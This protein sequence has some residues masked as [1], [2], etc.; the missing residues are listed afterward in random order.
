MKISQQGYLQQRKRLNP[1]IF[2]TSNDEYLIDFYESSEAGLCSKFR[3]ASND[4]RTERNKLRSSW[5]D[6]DTN[7]YRSASKENTP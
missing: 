2:S 4:Y 7:S 6:R 1:D 3:L 5:G